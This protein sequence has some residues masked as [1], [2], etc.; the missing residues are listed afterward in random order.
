M[1]LNI[2]A[3]KTTLPGFESWDIKDGHQGYPLAV[4]DNSLEEIYASHVLEHF[5]HGQ[6]L[7]VLKDWFRALQPGGLLRLSV[8]DFVKLANALLTGNKEKFPIEG[9]IMGGQTDPDDYH[10]ALF[11]ETKLRFLLQEAGFA[12]IAPWTSDNPDCSRFALSLNLQG[13]K[14]SKKLGIVKK[15]NEPGY[16][17]IVAVWSCPRLGFMATFESVYQSLPALGIPIMRGMG[18]FWGEQFE[19]LMEDVIQKQH[20]DALLAL[21]YDGIWQMADVE[22]LIRLFQLYPEADAIA[23][24]QWN[25]SR[26]KPLWTVTGRNDPDNYVTADELLSKGDLF[27]VNT[28]HFGLTL[29]RTSSLSKMMHPWFISIPG[30]GGHWGT[31]KGAVDAD[32]SFWKTF[33]AAGNRAFV[34]PRVVIGHLQETIRWPA[35]D[36]RSTLLQHPYE[37]YS[38]GK[39]KT[40]FA[41]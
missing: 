2:G 15:P 8:P 16:P 28:A 27:P 26:E 39:P 38:K 19:I 25:R 1:K 20:P 4:A 14:P 22:E 41:S 7:D 37:Y 21:D 29:I 40:A 36:F 6:T 10:R 23:A 32:I 13:R 11:I 33:E 24:N 30:D 31:D 12:D 5:P 34:A 3:G 35:A 17:K 9:A 18:V